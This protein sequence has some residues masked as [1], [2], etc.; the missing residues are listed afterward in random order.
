MRQHVAPRGG[1]HRVWSLKKKTPLAPLAGD[2]GLRGDLVDHKSLSQ[3][4]F[5]LSGPRDVLLDLQVGRP[6]EVK[7]P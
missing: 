3:C 7:I 6:W 1:R 2:A 5:L 4:F